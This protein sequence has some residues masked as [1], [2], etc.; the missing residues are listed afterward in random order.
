MASTNLAIFQRL[1]SQYASAPPSDLAI[2]IRIAAL[3][4]CA[5]FNAP[6]AT[7]ELRTLAAIAM[8][9]PLA[10]IA[11]SITLPLTMSALELGNNRF[12]LGGRP[13]SMALSKSLAEKPV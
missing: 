1:T 5:A 10:I 3:A 7:K 11:R 2:S 13:I 12:M 6:R 8:A 9:W 4:F